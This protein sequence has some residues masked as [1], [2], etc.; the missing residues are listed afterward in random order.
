MKP[1]DLGYGKRTI[2][3]DFYRQVDKACAATP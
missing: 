3:F 1:E 2:D